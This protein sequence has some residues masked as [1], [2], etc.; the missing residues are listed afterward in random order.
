[1]M[2]HYIASSAGFLDIVRYYRIR[3]PNLM[4]STTGLEQQAITSPEKG[5]STH[6]ANGNW[7]VKQSRRSTS[8]SL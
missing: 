8:V 1:M 4:L 7:G 5:A 2:N 6:I 3:L